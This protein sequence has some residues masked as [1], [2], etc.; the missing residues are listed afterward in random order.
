M[1]YPRPS[2]DLAGRDVCCDAED[3][4]WSRERAIAFR[5]KPAHPTR[6]SM[7]F[8]DRHHVA[9]TTWVDLPDTTWHQLPLSL[10][11]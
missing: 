1:E 4:N 5:A 9:F 6:L 10:N 11:D 3:R 2:D 8:M 7:S